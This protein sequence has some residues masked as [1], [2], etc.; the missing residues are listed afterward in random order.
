[1]RVVYEKAFLEYEIYCFHSPAHVMNGK[2]LATATR[3]KEQQGERGRGER[4][5]SRYRGKAQKK[6]TKMN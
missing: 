4:R 2:P 3:W 6:K 5:L 1:M